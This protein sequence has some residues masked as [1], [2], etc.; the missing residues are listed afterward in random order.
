[1]PDA[2]PNAPKSQK[3]DRRSRR[4]RFEADEHQGIDRPQLDPP[5]LPPEADRIIAHL[6]EVG[7]ATGDGVVSWQELAAWEDLSCNLVEPWEATLLRRLSA[8]FVSTR[9][10][11][12]D[13]NCP[14]PGTEVQRSQMAPEVVSDQLKAMFLGLQAQHERDQAS[15]KSAGAR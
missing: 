5:P 14:M 3:T 6:F 10:R 8:E 4:E 15:G 12:R 1:M 9:D 7:P 11:A 13:A 2:P